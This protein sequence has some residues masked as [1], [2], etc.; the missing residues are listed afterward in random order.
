MDTHLK[1]PCTFEYSQGNGTGVAEAIGNWG[2]SSQIG[3][4][5]QELRRLKC[6]FAKMDAL[7]RSFSLNHDSTKSLGHF[8]PKISK[9]QKNSGF[10]QNFREFLFARQ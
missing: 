10:S 6:L 8:D 5:G 4:S 7:L 2:F 9:K 1:M 3:S